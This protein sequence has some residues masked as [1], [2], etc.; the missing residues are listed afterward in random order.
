MLLSLLEVDRQTI[1][2]VQTYGIQIQ[3]KTSK[4]YSSL[5]VKTFLSFFAF[6][7]HLK[8]GKNYTIF[9]V[10]TFL[11][12]LHLHFKKKSLPPLKH[13]NILP[14]PSSQMLKKRCKRDHPSLLPNKTNAARIQ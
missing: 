6:A 1:H 10:N 12:G 2:T 14:M 8:S 13:C 7:L 11:V 9:E 5:E 4:N 3:R